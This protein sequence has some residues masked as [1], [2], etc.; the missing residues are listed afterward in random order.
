MIVKSAR[1]KASSQG[2]S[3][4][5]RHVFYGADNEAIEV[6]QG[7]EFD[8]KSELGRA[9]SVGS[10]YAV[11]HV[12]ISSYEDMTDE[13]A[14]ELV[15]NYAREFKAD[16]SKST[17]V[18]H[19]KQ[20]AD[21]KASN[22]H[23]HVYFPE[24]LANGKIMD[25]SFS[26]IREEKIARIAEIDFNHRPVIGKHNNAV[27]K[28][29]EKSGRLY[30]A[31][32]IRKNTPSL[33]P[34]NAPNA[35]YS[36]KQFRR[37]KVN[38]I[39]LNEVR[40]TIKDLRISSESFSQ[41]YEQ[42]LDIGLDIKKGDKA[43]T[44]IV[45][46]S[47]NQVLGSANRLFGMKKQDF[48]NMYES[49]QNGID[50]SFKP[51]EVVA[52][53]SQP[54]ATQAPDKP[55]T[56]T[57]K[58]A[59]QHTMKEAVPASLAGPKGVSV[60]SGSGADAIKADHFE[61]TSSMSKEQKAF[62]S[63]QND[64]ANKKA[65]LEKEALTNQKKFADDL[66]KMMSDFSNR[67]KHIPPEPFAD[68][69]TRDKYHIQQQLDGILTPLRDDYLVK[70][71]NAGWFNK[72]PAKLA[73][74]AFQDKLKQLHFDEFQGLDLVN[75]KKDFSYALKCM[76]SKYAS[77]REQKHKKWSSTLDVVNYLNAKKD[78]NKLVFLIEK[79]KDIELLELAIKSP[80]LAIEAMKTKKYVNNNFHYQNNINS[81]NHKNIPSITL[82]N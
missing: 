15:K 35:C 62:I 40:Q 71:E 81:M 45:V 9:K 70:H 72:K 10:K 67:W 6:L 73:L 53:A 68:P 22:H 60:S 51:L 50:T 36:E 41:L 82:Y 19:T 69:K 30:Y 25:S 24:V 78:I 17:I 16:V 58:Q 46:N 42:M 13:Q 28:D 2:M 31:D 23:Y 66:L 74:K 29:L 43:N 79:Y 21:G 39:Q 37:A 77:S 3:S 54:Q 33:D 59:P 8:V 47:E 76:A 44:Y 56:A 75:N 52:S 1:M 32:V 4:T 65:S 18:K 26:K 12:K 55:A 49:L 80:A 63:F 34:K 48:N 11:R 20:R 14:F 27:I 7:S 38:G 57:I 5:C 64:E 61:A